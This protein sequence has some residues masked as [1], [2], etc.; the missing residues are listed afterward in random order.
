MLRRPLWR[1]AAVNVAGQAVPAF[2]YAAVVPLLM[3]ALGLARF[4]VFALVWTLF[5][6]LTLFDLGLGRGTARAAAQAREL[7][8]REA[9]SRIAG[10]SC[11]LLVSLGVAAGGVL[12]TTAPNMA[13]WLRLPAEVHSEATTTFRLAGA[14]LPVFLAAWGLQAVL[15]G[16]RWFDAVAIA[17]TASGLLTALGLAGAARVGI[18]EMVATMGGTRMLYFLVLAWLTGKAVPQMWTR[19]LVDRRVAEELVG[20]GRWVLIHAWMASLL[21]YG[22]RFLVALLRGAADVSLYVVPQET[23]LRLMLVPAAVATAVYPVLSGRQAAGD[24]ENVRRTYTEG[25]WLVGVLLGPCAVVLALFAGELL[26]AWIGPQAHGSAGALRVLAVGGLLLGYA[27]VPSVAFA[28]VGRPDIPA[29]VTLAL[30]P[31]YLGAAAIAIQVYGA[32][33]AAVA[34]AVRAG[35]QWA[36]YAVLLRRLFFPGTAGHERYGLRSIVGWFAASGVAAVLGTFLGQGLKAGVGLFG[37]AVL[38]LMVHRR[39]VRTNVYTMR[40]REQCDGGGPFTS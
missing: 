16:L 9:L 13:A 35:A 20:F 21:T 38:G 30:T 3:H 26:H 17:K 8:D 27:H 29:R 23:V 28:A 12:W 32:T 37:A 11:L 39:A 25:L 4:G 33:G 40:G 34:W 14:V 22:D 1:N 5:A 19:P 36:A 2:A 7:G 10:T 24:I 6:Y 15:E 31:V 18:P